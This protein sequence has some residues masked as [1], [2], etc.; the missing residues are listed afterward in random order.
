ME[1]PVQ[2]KNL[3]LYADDDNDDLQFVQEAFSNHAKDIE[4]KTFNSAIE[5]LDFIHHRKKDR[6]LPCLIILDINMPGMNGKDALKFI[7]KM[8]RYKEVP[9][10]LFTTSSAPHDMRFAGQY[11]AG[12]FTKPLNY[13]QMKT[14]VEKFLDHCNEAIK[15]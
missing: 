9:V 6:P 4:L 12:F 3:V 13:R 11:S 10:I 5:L 1:K 15:K 8:N 14:I 2:P 7:R